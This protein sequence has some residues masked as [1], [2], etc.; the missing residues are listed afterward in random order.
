M[1]QSLRWVAAKLFLFTIVTVVITI[2][3]AS[4]IGNFKLFDDPYRLTASF[5]D[6]TGLLRGDVVKAAGVTVGR[7]DHIAIDRGIA[8]VTMTIDVDTPLPNNLGA[9]VRYRNLIGQRMIT[10][11]PVTG[12]EASGEFED[13]DEIALERTKP[14]FDLSVLFNGLRPLIRSTN[15]EDINLV[16]R[17]LTKSLEGRGRD[18]ES[19]LANLSAMSKTLVSKDAQLDQ[20]L[21]GVNVVTEDLAGRDAQLR[22]T[23]ADF[24]DF[25]GDLEASRDELDQALVTLDDAADKINRLVERNDEN[26]TASVEDLEVILDVVNDRREDLRAAVEALPTMLEAVERVTS[27]GEW[28]NVHLINVCRDET[29]ECGMRGML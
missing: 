14:A 1:I 5:T 11:V 6:A 16:A 22:R 20:L 28:Q 9:E 24:G 12:E 17:E 25:L 4:T 21:D 2:W 19:F 15:P 26:I 27:Y 3:L 7:V 13:G 23:L 8:Q 10:L 18:V 29:G